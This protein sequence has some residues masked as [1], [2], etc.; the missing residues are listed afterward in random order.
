MNHS[1]L[2]TEVIT[3]SIPRSLGNDAFTHSPYF[4]GWGGRT[5]WKTDNLESPK[6][7]TH[8]KTELLTDDSMSEK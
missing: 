7:T 6:E 1:N 8:P 3:D 2:A 5:L 4:R